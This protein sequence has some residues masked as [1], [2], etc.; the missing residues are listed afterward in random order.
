MQQIA[1]E[2]RPFLAL[3]IVQAGGGRVAVIGYAYPGQPVNQIIRR[4]QELAH[5]RE[6]IRFVQAQPV[7]V[8]RG[9]S[10]GNGLGDIG[11]LRL[12]FNFLAQPG[13]QVAG[14]GIVPHQ[15]RAH[16]PAVFIQHHQRVHLSG[17]A[18]GVHQRGIKL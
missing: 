6:V 3:H 18:H 11:A 9:A 4:D 13:H 7:Q 14:A 16:R 2:R 12:L 17:H 15:R 5:P 8:G 1:H 10:G